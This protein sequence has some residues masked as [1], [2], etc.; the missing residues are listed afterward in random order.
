MNTVA[1]FVMRMAYQLAA[2]PYT[3]TYLLTDRYKITGRSKMTLITAPFRT[4]RTL[5]DHLHVPRAPSLLPR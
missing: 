2:K 1:V 5:R 4:C 3:S